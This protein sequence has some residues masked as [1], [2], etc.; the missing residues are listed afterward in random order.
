MAFVVIPHFSPDHKSH[1]PEILGRYTL[2][3]VDEIVHGTSPQPNHIY[4][5]PA[6][7]R[8]CLAGGKLLLEERGAD[9]LPH[10]I[11]FFFRSLAAHQ[12]TRAVG[13]VLSGTHSDGA[14]GLKSIKGE[15]GITMVQ[16]PESARFS[17][18]P[19]TS[20]SADHV[21]RVLP[22]RRS[23]PNW[24]NSPGSSG[25]RWCR[26]W[27]RVSRRANSITLARIL[28]LLRTVSGV[29]F[30]LYR[31]STIHRR[32]ARRMLLHRIQSLAEYAAY[33]QG[34]YKELRRDLQEDALIN[35]TRFFRDPPV[36]DALKE[37]VLPRI[38]EGRPEDQ[39]VRVWV[40]GCATGEEAYSLAI[41][42]LEYLASQA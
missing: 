14:L 12:K 24:R 4:V 15:G 19:R 33:V 39:Q 17:E 8:A 38:F 5:I 20:I 6:N 22:P 29:D 30:R 26:I 16:S 25:S 10:P 2:L 42:V 9:S 3:P 32:I 23:P 13:V 18:M 1:L 40:A 31:P 21:D 34:N 41:A 27:R 37:V 35:V 7:A 11:D 36:F 28:T